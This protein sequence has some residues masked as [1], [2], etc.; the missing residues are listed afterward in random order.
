MTLTEQQLQL[1]PRDSVQGRFMPIDA[2]FKSLAESHRDW[3]IA[4][5]LSGLDGDGAAGLECIKQSG[6]I[7]FAQNEETARHD[8]M[9]SSAIATG[10]VDFVLS[11]TEIAR[12]L[13]NIARHPYLDPSLSPPADEIET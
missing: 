1:V 3:A 11:P 12:E 13:A 2:F 9:P 10:A 5:V 6:G 8:G 7:T 4:V